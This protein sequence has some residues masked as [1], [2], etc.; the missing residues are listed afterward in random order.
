M[1]AH[2]QTSNTDTP[3][4]NIKI[5]LDQTKVGTINQC[6]IIT[7]GFSGTNHLPDSIKLQLIHRYWNF[8]TKKVFVF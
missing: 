2:I 6:I 3:H 8:G 7:V 1:Y 4:W 5:I